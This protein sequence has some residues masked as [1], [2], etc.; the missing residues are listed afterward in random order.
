MRCFPQLRPSW[1]RAI[2]SQGLLYRKSPV[3]KRTPL[4]VCQKWLMSSRIVKSRPRIR[5]N[6]S[7][8]S[9]AIRRVFSERGSS[10]G[11]TPVSEAWKAWRAWIIARSRVVKSRA[12]PN[13]DALA[14]RLAPCWIWLTYSSILSVN[15]LEPI[16]PR[17]DKLTVA[18]KTFCKAGRAQQNPKRAMSEIC[19]TNDRDERSQCLCGGWV[20]DWLRNGWEVGV[21]Q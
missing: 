12:R 20:C 3:S 16:R 10:L 8:R 21:G 2:H 14:E 18:S 9:L 15:M 19:C 7:W 11:G 4:P 6:S 17:R 5:T 13:E 1:T